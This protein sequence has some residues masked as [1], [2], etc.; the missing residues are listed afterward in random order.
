MTKYGNRK[1]AV[2]GIVFDSLH[3]ANRWRDLRLMQS[4]GVISGLDRQVSF[5]LMPNVR[6][7]DG[8]MIRGIKYIADFVYTDE[9]GRRIVEDAKGMQTEVYKLKK[10]MMLWIYGIEIQEV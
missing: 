2:D 7:R 1:T 3:E 6:T 9:Y 4:A 5:E 10:K 8:K